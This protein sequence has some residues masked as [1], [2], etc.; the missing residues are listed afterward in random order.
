M[1]SYADEAISEKARNWD[2]RA[3]LRP[4]RNDIRGVCHD[5]VIHPYRTQGSICLSASTLV[6]SWCA[7]PRTLGAIPD[8]VLAP[9]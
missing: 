3:S 9:A 4:A 2:C 1:V 5:R 7:F 8:A 6:V